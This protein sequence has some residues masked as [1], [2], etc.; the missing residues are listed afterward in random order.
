MS[1][2]RAINIFSPDGHIH[3]V[4]YAGETVK[5]GLAAVG[6]K[7]GNVVV[8][9]V[10]KKSIQQLQDPRT[11]RKIFKLDEHAVC[12]FAGMSA[13]ARVLISK[14]Q[15]QCQSFRMHY[16]DPMNVDYIVRHMAE[17]QQRA[18]QLGGSRPYGVATIVGGYNSDGSLQLWQTE[19]SGMTAS[20]K[21]CAIGRN[22]KSVVEYMEKAYTEGMDRA[23]AVRFTVRALL[24]V[25]ES[26]AKNIELLVIQPGQ[27][28]APVGD[29]E[30]SALV[31]ELDKECEEAR[32]AKRS[33]EE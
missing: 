6:V 28:I 8:I 30:L 5:R 27:P 4:E 17:T 11:V 3:Q 33:E 9:G 14:I 2:D 12:A 7:G 1:Y 15:G 24:E 23:T 18:T 29:A 26:G 22:A 32:A 13:D 16:D 21:A 19:P 31:V 20:W 10:E 25:V